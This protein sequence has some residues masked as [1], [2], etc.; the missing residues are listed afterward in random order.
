[1]A[2]E[3]KA[4]FNPMEDLARQLRAGNSFGPSGSAVAETGD[5]GLDQAIAGFASMANSVSADIDSGFG[6]V[7]AGVEHEIANFTEADSR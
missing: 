3:V 4:T 1:M 7:A 5:S 6:H 2:D